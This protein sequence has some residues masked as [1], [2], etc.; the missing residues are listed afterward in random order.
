MKYVEDVKTIL[1]GIIWIK[2][3]EMTKPKGNPMP[4]DFL[5]RG[6]LAG[7]RKY[8]E[9]RPGYF[10]AQFPG[11]TIEQAFKQAT[12]AYQAL[13]DGHTGETGADTHSRG[14]KVMARMG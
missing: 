2:G 5:D 11:M 8:M 10:Q 3:D 13:N 12:G 1:S 7:F 9:A 14:A 6:T 4:I